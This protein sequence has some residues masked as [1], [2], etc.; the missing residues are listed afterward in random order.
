M[1]HRVVLHPSHQ[2][3][4]NPGRKFM[5]VGRRKSVSETLRDTLLSAGPERRE[6]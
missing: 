5:L 4:E 1:I 3:S 6:V 2:E